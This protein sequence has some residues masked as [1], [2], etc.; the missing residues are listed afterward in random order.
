MITD[1]LTFALKQSG[2]GRNGS[3]DRVLNALTTARQSTPAG[4]GTKRRQVRSACHAVT[5]AR[6]RSTN[7][8]PSSTRPKKEAFVVAAQF[9]RDH[10]W[11]LRLLSATL[12]RAHLRNDEMAREFVRTRSSHRGRSLYPTAVPKRYPML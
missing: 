3:G 7:P 10:P 6:T 8:A 2:R 4:S 5:I 1:A 9:P 11:R 12:G